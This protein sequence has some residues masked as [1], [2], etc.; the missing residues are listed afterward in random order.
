MTRKRSF[1]TRLL[2]V[3]VIFLLQKYDCRGLQIGPLPT[4]KGFPSTPF[5]LAATARDPDTTVDVSAMEISAT[6]VDLSVD[7]DPDPD[8]DTTYV[9]EIN[10]ANAELRRKQPKEENYNA[11]DT[12]FF[13]TVVKQDKR[14]KRTQTIA[15]STTL[16]I[17]REELAENE[18]SDRYQG[19]P[20]TSSPTHATGE[21]GRRQMLEQGVAA[22]FGTSIVAGAI[23]GQPD[24][25]PPTKPVASFPSVLQKTPTV[26]IKPPQ[27]KKNPTTTTTSA[28]SNAGRLEPVNLTQVAAETNINI[29]MACDDGCVKVDP[30]NFTK[31]K[32]AKLPS[33]YPSFLPT[34]IP[35][36][37]KQIDDR[38]LLVAASIAG[39]I[40]EMVRT[41]I[42]YPIQTI[43]VRIQTDI[44][45][46]T[47]RPPPIDAR[48]K[49]LGYNIGRF[50][51]EGNLYAGIKPSLLV[52]V[53]ATGVYYGVRD[54]SK[55]MLQMTPMGDIPIALA[56]AFFGDIVSLCLRTPADALTLRLQS[57][58]DED[59]VGDWFGDS[60]KRLPMVIVTDLPYLL[61]KILLTRTFIH[62]SISVDH[63][64]EIAI[65]TSIL[66]AF[67]TTPFD[68]VRTRI[69]ID[70]DGNFSNGI[71]GGSSEGVIKTMEDVM[72][73][74][75]GGVAN[76]YAGWFERVLYLGI[77]R[78]WLEPLQIIGYIGIRDALLLEWF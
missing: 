19:F 6:Y 30:K 3:Y 77:G 50:S 69:L 2:P 42:L 1:V 71:D 75:R 31:V 68:V 60:I 49:K 27:K 9:S 66:A 74:G 38:E 26:P 62:G 37:I 16:E 34:P 54:V 57:N 24:P 78:A 46:Y 10:I 22:L 39:G 23:L 40:T 67:L 8:P 33:W 76:L 11:V 36:V 63:Y 14:N 20:T 51:Q 32:S 44:H 56:A 48:I 25:K 35:K 29:T 59:D 12:P 55:R 61:S 18:K 43:K 15:T 4:R 65:L 73:E 52:S 45:N 64:A 28:V 13:A 58:P 47:L 53:P 7:P 41:S 5:W 72:R 21:V 70:S 17:A